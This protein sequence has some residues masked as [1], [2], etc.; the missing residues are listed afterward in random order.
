[1]ADARRSLLRRAGTA[2]NREERFQARS[3]RVAVPLRALITGS[4]RCGTTSV[5]AFLDGTVTVAGGRV[6]ASHETAGDAL[7]DL[8]IAG[9]SEAAQRWLRALPHDVE[10]N[11]YLI[12]FDSHP[13]P[14]IPVLGLVR[15]ARRTLVSGMNTGWYLPPD[16]GGARWMRLL[17]RFPGSRF[18]Q[19]CSFW[20]WSIAKMRRIDATIFRIE[21]L[22]TDGMTRIALVRAVTGSEPVEVQGLPHRNRAAQTKAEVAASAGS[23]AMRRWPE[24][25][26][27]ELRS[28]A[29]IC[30][31]FMDEL[32]PGWNVLPT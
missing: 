13:L 20:A 31:P 17:P 3:G 27:A 25:S 15:D 29:R 21:D 7:P 22:A 18:E 14:E 28:F 26:G 10:V 1:M 30:G 4:G 23:S 12:F 2:R 9:K 6:R 8:L 16:A 11:P 19:C 32:Y 24:W 5:A